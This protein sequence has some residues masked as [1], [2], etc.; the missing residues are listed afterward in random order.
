MRL[1]RMTVRQRHQLSDLIVRP[2]GLEAVAVALCGR[3]VGLDR[4]AYTVRSII[5]IPIEACVRAVDSVRWPTRKIYDAL[6]QCRGEDLAV[7]KL[8]SHPAGAAFFST[9]DD[10]S[11]C[12]LLSAVA[13][14]IGG[15][16]LSA[17]ITHDGQILARTVDAQG[18]FAP[19]DRI[20]V[21]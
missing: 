2:D 14:R 16:Q 7:L 17:V 9:I 19:V 8:H 10:A 11:D 20:V 21:G 3:Q 15:E 6:D 18:D 4:T 1:L 13:R 12:E 5:P